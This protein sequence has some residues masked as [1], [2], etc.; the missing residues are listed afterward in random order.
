M[1]ATSEAGPQARSGATDHGGKFLTFFLDEEEYGIEILTVREIIGLMPVTTVPQTPYHVRGVVNLRGQV[2]PVVDLRVKFDMEPIEDTEQTCI[3][4]V[5][6]RG[7][8]LG[9]V[10]DQ[11][12]EVL[13]IAG[14]DIVDPPTLGTEI[15]TDYILGIGKQGDRVSLLLDIDVVF[16]SEE[17]GTWHEAA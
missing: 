6:T 5:Q 7:I 3:I 11:V 15:K 13:D 10:V 9:V 12:S 4:V 16:G 8:M 14:K 17:P 2:I 1:S